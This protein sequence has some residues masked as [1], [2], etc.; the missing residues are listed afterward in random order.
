MKRLLLACLMAAALVPGMAR[1]EVIVSSIVSALVSGN[2][3]SIALIVSR[4]VGSI[5]AGSA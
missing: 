5:A 1:A 4:T 2:A 3:G